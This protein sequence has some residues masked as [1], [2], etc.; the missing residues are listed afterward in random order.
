MP[1]CFQ[2]CTRVSVFRRKCVCGVGWGGGVSGTVVSLLGSTA[3]VLSAP[4]QEP[5]CFTQNLSQNSEDRWVKTTTDRGNITQGQGVPDHHLLNISDVPFFG[6]GGRV[7][8]HCVLWAGAP[9]PLCGRAKPIG[10][11][12]HALGHALV[13]GCYHHDQGAQ[14]ALL[15]VFLCWGVYHLS[16]MCVCMFV[17]GGGGHFFATTATPITPL[18]YLPNP[19][20]V[21]L[22]RDLEA[23]GRTS[24]ESVC[25]CVP[26]QTSPRAS[27]LAPKLAHLVTGLGG[28]GAERRSQFANWFPLGRHVSLWHPG[29]GSLLERTLTWRLGGSFFSSCWNGACGCF[30][31]VAEPCGEASVLKC[32]KCLLHQ[33]P[34]WT[35]DRLC[36]F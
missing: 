18:V 5:S 14:A 30:G 36:G 3:S 10:P 35:L 9:G 8:W 32:F 24:L 27:P 7:A 28:G 21:Q 33:G 23:W 20:P 17:G 26:L 11:F 2:V 34:T 31:V 19:R 6:G 12:K 15:C 13:P 29:K 25:P 1:V 22:S 4:M 16:E